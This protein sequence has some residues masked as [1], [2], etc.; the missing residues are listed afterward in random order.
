MSDMSNM[1]V[2]NDEGKRIVLID[3][4]DARRKDLIHSVLE[5]FKD[6]GAS[7]E[8]LEGEACRLDHDPD[9][10]KEWVVYLPKWH[11]SGIVI[12]NNNNLI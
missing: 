8:Q 10:F 4:K 5:A 1:I 2:T 7:D 12:E 6:M 9:Y 3:N 11:D